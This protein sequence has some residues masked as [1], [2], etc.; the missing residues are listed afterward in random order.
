MSL[1]A[2]I[3]KKSWTYRSKEGNNGY[4]EWYGETRRH[5]IEGTNKNE[6]IKHK[7]C[8]SSHEII[9]K[10]LNLQKQRMR[11]LGIQR[12]KNEWKRGNVLNW[13]G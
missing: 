11:Y 9:F 6:L 12:G 3:L 1:N 5:Y 8:V 2:D 10:N 4:L 13:T 7:Y